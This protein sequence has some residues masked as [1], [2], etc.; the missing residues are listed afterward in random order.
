[1]TSGY[2]ACTDNIASKQDYRDGERNSLLA[3][4]E[5]ITYR[6]VECRNLTLEAFDLTFLAE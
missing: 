6:I 4:L 2:V 5:Y 1:M 3:S